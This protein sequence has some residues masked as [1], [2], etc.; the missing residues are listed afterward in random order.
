MAWLQLERSRNEVGVDMRFKNRAD[1]QIS[2]G[3][4]IEIDLHITTWI[5]DGDISSRFIR[6][7]I[8]N[9][10]KPGSENTIDDHFDTAPF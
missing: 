7:K 9:L 6:N 1:M 4:P 3:S 5:N 8:R 10:R 2:L